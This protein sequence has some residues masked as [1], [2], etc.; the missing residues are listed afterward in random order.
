MNANIIG[1]E[2]NF[3]RIKYTFKGHLRPLLCQGEIR[4]F[5]KP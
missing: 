1:R 4:E 5:L 2:A 3:H